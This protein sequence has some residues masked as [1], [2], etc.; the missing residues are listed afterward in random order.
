MSRDTYTTTSLTTAVSPRM[1]IVNADAQH[2]AAELSQRIPGLDVVALLPGQAVP[3]AA[4]N[5]S[6]AVGFASALTADLINQLPNLRWIQALS[7]GV[8]GIVSLPNLPTDVVLTSAHGVHGPAVSELTLMLMLALSRDFASLLDNQRQHVWKRR[9]QPLLHGKTLVVLGTGLIACAL[10]TRCRA[11]GMRTVAVSAAVRPVAEFDQVVARSE[12]PV[13]AAQADFLVA[14]TPL[15]ESS[16]GL[17]DKQVF[18]AMKAS[19]YF[20]NV[21]RAGVCDVG[22][23][24]R[25]LNAGTIAGAALDVFTTE[26]LPADDPL[27]DVPRLIITPHLGGESDRYA[28]QVLPILEANGR[29]FVEGRWG[30]MMNRV[31]IPDNR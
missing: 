10:A 1:L 11:L 31:S 9:S 19:A 28:D 5:A 26:P 6:C 7:S 15:D 12:L 16:R 21:A 24:V 3:E 29:C 30:E 20:I 25:A 22:A 27:W 14:L 13:V 2:Y 23:L 18:D 4:R 17:V 8:D